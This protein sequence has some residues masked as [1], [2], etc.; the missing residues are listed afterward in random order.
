MWLNFQKGKEFSHHVTQSSSPSF[1]RTHISHR[2][3]CTSP[4]IP[5]SR[6]GLS[7]GGSRKL[8]DS[9]VH[10]QGPAPARVCTWLFL[11]SPSECVV[12]GAG[13]SRFLTHLW[14]G[15]TLFIRGT[16]RAAKR[17]W[18]LN[19]PL[20]TCL[21]RKS[22]PASSSSSYFRSGSNKD[23]PKGLWTG[24]SYRMIGTLK[25]LLFKML[26][27]TLSSHLQRAEITFLRERESSSC[28]IFRSSGHPNVQL[29]RLTDLEK[30]TRRSTC[31]PTMP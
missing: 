4:H 2:H 6:S 9:S 22:Q 15:K 20:G 27:V 12:A 30:K 17:Y 1:L 11:W 21:T 10:R 19:I 24:L 14:N 31:P 29:T 23:H 26:S 7:Q 13:S 28:M 8:L 3:N 18:H 16:N 25:L 5:L